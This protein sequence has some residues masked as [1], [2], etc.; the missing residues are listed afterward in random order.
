VKT[1]KPHPAPIAIRT[2]TSQKD[3]DACVALQ[4]ETWGSDFPE[5]A[6]TGILKIVQKV[7]GI[8]AGAFDTNEQLVGFVFGISG[9]RN[10]TQAHWSH[11]LA[12]VGEHQNSGLGRTLKEFQ[13]TSLLEMGISRMYWTFDPL[14]ARN[15]H[16]N[17]NR[18]GVQIESYV[19]SMYGE[20]DRGKLDSVIGTDRFIADWNL[21]RDPPSSP[22][23]LPE[24]IQTV[25]TDFSN[26]EPTPRDT[27]NAGGEVAYVEIPE[28][29][30]EL[31]A[32]D[33]T[34]AKAWRSS[35]RQAFG[36]LLTDGYRVTGFA[37]DK[38]TM[39]CLYELRRETD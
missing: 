17:L 30:G 28:E 12:V 25:N 19:E 22:I 36:T 2:L 7:G 35:T 39:R 5:M 13:K 24:S 10:G 31:K 29:I 38:T 3:L 15:A 37:R 16:F 32:E 26:G 6:S 11:M 27:S 34:K 33:P 9:V 1:N 14:V 20:G 21:E 4:E 23:L 8:A 18:L